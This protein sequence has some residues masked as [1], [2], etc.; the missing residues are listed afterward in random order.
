MWFFSCSLS[1]GSN[2]RAAGVNT[3]FRLPPVEQITGVL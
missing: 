2:I 1:F 3:S